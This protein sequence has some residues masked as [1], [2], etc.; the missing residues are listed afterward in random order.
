LS[1]YERHYLSRCR[2]CRLVFAARIPTE[3]ELIRYYSRY[4]YGGETSISPITI[5]RYQEL[6]D[7]M[8]PWRKTN[9]ILDVGCGT[10]DF[11]EQALL[12]GWEVYGTEYSATAVKICR[13][14]GIPMQQGKLDTKHYDPASF[15]IVSSFEVIEHINNPR[16]DMANISSLLRKGGLFYCTTPNFNGLLR[17][18]LKDRYSVIAYPEHLT[19]YTPATL[20]S[21]CERFGLRKHRLF[22]TG[23]SLTRLRNSASPQAKKEKT[24]AD[25]AATAANPAQQKEPSVSEDEKL[26]QS[27]EKSQLLQWGKDLSNALFSATGTGLTIK[28]FFVKE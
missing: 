24:K 10:G 22:T 23:I 8:E 19:Y 16:E 9:K 18:Y 13:D 4:A 1:G 17:F 11:L 14:K 21:L 20:Q 6:L 28:A 3:E 15:D 5:Q 2:D 7:Q 25:L 12:R 27:I 26:R